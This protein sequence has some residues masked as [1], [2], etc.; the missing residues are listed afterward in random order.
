MDVAVGPG[1]YSHGTS[2]GI[3]HVVYES[4]RLACL[5]LGGELYDL[6]VFGQDKDITYP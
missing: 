1:G 5:S 2:V 3:I 4:R 6:D